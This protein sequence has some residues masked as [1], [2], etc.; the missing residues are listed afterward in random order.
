[1]TAVRYEHGLAMVRNQSYSGIALERGSDGLFRAKFF[2]EGMLTENWLSKYGIADDELW[3]PE[4]DDR[5]E[6]D[7]DELALVD[8]K[9]FFGIVFEADKGV[10]RQMCLYTKNTGWVDIENTEKGCISSIDCFFPGK[11]TFKFNKNRNGSLSALV[12]GKH[13]AEGVE[14]ALIDISGS[15]DFSASISMSGSFDK[16]F[17]DELN[18][19]IRFYSVDVPLP[20]E[21]KSIT[22]MRCSLNSMTV[23]PIKNTLDSIGFEKAKEMT[24]FSLDVNLDAL[25]EMIG[26]AKVKEVVFEY[27]NKKTPVPTELVEAIKNACPGLKVEVNNPTHT[28]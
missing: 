17:I 19:R 27:Q 11:Y 28:A 7:H 2:Q 21:Y 20:K 10:L 23:E 18:D 16:N 13:S 12:Y 24:V 1:M 14:G 9:L 15:E 3:I 8:G 22:Y 25:L 6:Y 4:S 5:V 26:F